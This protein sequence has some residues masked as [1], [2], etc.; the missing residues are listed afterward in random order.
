MVLTMIISRIAVS[1]ISRG[2]L[3][4]LTLSGTV[5]ASPAFAEPLPV[6]SY[7]GHT[8]PQEQYLGYRPSVTLFVEMDIETGRY[9]A[10]DANQAKFN[11][12]WMDQDNA[13]IGNAAVKALIKVAGKALYRR[14]YQ[15]GNAERYHLP[16]EDGRINVNS[17]DFYELDYRLHVSSD[18]LSVGM[19]MNF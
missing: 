11:R 9:Q 17:D 5:L 4:L 6:Q 10:I 15:L 19:V 16:D 14:L 18:S 1:L 7:N 8:L 12:A 2:K 3:L 13:K